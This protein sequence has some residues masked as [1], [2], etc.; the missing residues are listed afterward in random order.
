MPKITPCLWFDTQAEEA[1]R[2]Y[3]SVFKNSKINTITHYGDFMPNRKGTVLTV[4]F[5]LDGQRFTAL[6]GGPEF[7]FNEAVSLMIHCKDQDEIDDYWAKLGQGGQIL[8]CGWLKDRYGLAWQV[9][10]EEMEKWFRDPDQERVN[11]VMQAVLR[12]KKL[13]IE[14]LRRVYEESTAS[15]ST[16][17]SS[18]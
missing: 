14:P 8:E 7:K 15:A 16:A 6:N 2:F 17:N 10:P 12:M 11:R 9:V 3:T 18:R 5:E 13:E 4:E 1:A